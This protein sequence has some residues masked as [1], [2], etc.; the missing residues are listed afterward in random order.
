MPKRGNETAAQVAANRRPR[1]ACPARQ[2]AQAFLDS[3]G[4]NPAFLDSAQDHC[5]CELCG[6]GL[7]MTATRGGLTYEL[8][9]GFVGFGIQMGPRAA[10]LRIFDDWAVSYHGIK[11]ANISSVLNEGGLLL[12]GDTLL[13]GSTLQAAHTR[14]AYRNRLYTSPSVHYAEKPVY[15][16]PIEF[17]SQRMRVVLQCRQ[18]PDFEV[19][20]ETIGWEQKHP[21]VAISPHFPNS[22]LEW[23]TT[24]RA[25]IVPYRILI[26]MDDQKFRIQWPF[27][28]YAVRR[29]D[30][31]K[32]DAQEV[33]KIGDVVKTACSLEFIK[34]GNRVEIKVNALGTIKKLMANGGDLLHVEFADS[35]IGV[36]AVTSS[37]IR[38]CAP[39]EFFQVG[40]T[41]K[42][43]VKLEYKELGVVVE[44]GTLGTL[45]L[46][47]GSSGVKMVDW[48]DVRSVEGGYA[49]IE[50][51]IEKLREDGFLKG[52]DTVKAI[53]DLDFG[54][55][56]GRVAAGS[57]GSLIRADCTPGRDGHWFVNWGGKLTNASSPLRSVI[58]CTPSEFF[59]PGDV[60]RPVQNLRITLKA[61]GS[62]AMVSL[63]GVPAGSLTITED[64][65]G[66]IEALGVYDD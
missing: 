12:P 50:G 52:G 5:Y 3:L 60:V 58:K 8:P 29:S 23:F 55:Q 64:T 59:R 25:A 19:C 33:W 62:S 45:K 43:A 7:P 66:T 30:V 15:T 9:H 36:A 63:P 24:K 14:D 22:Q 34:D 61:A 49:V 65:L 56:W 32:C 48:N 51:Q 46:L 27:G 26:K 37:Q 16:E 6:K 41:V 31:V 18:K 2:N 39:Q 53:D 10:S 35:P 38:K 4:V 21:G 11:A 57:L 20:G 54:K 17:S 47:Q 28:S 40:D 13:D 44:A 1:V 42:A